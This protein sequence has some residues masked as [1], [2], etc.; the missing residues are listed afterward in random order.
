MTAVTL[1]NE[2]LQL[3][4]SEE[5]ILAFIVEHEEKA[6]ASRDVGTLAYEEIKQ[7]LIQHQVNF[8]Q[9]GQISI[10]LNC[11]GKII[12]YADHVEFAVLRDVMKRLLQ[13]RGFDNINRFKRLG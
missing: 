13:E 4:L 8:R 2:A 12:Y 6:A 10:P 1:A 9:E 5:G 11:W 7:V 3:G